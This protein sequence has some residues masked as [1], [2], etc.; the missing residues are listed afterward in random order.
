MAEPARF[1]ALRHTAVLAFRGPEA[2]HF[3][4]GQLS[5]DV[6]QL[7]PTRMQLAGLHNPQGRVIAL[8]RL[9]Q[10]EPGEILALLPRELALPVTEQLRRYVLRAKVQILDASAEF[11]LL[12]IESEASAAA[13]AAL[14]GMPL[15]QETQSARAYALLPAAMAI[16]PARVHENRLVWERLELSAGIPHLGA[17]T[18]GQFIAQMLNLDLLHAISFTKGCYTGQEVIARAHYRGRVKRRLQRFVAP[19]ERTLPPASSWRLSDGRRAQ[20]VRA[21]PTPD[22]RMEFLAVAPLPSASG[23]SEEEVAGSEAGQLECTGLPLPYALPEAPGGG[24]T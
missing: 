2:A 9:L 14:G 24:S 18:S 16:D 20:I 13:S 1:F 7:L 12:G 17:A 5:A 8:L 10:R 6:G 19:S 22:Q 23:T 3:L 11:Q 4:Q 21:L 15:I